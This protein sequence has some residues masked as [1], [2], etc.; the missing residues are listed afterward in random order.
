VKVRIVF[1]VGIFTLINLTGD[2]RAETSRTA[3]SFL[4]GKA[5]LELCEAPDQTFQHGWCLG[6]IGGVNDGLTNTYDSPNNFYYCLRVP[7]TA[8]QLSFVVLKHLEAHPEELRLVASHVVIQAL[9]EA[10]PCSK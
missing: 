8:D 2:L 1:I 5:L 9:G 3:Y 6:F 4:N 10:F 7:V